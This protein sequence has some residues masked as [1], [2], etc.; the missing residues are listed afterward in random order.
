MIEIILNV[1]PVSWT[2]S[3]IV[4]HHAYNPKGAEK[5]ATQWLIAQEYK[6]A[7]LAGYVKV[8][9]VFFFQIPKSA[10]KKRRALMLSGDIIP[11]SKDNTNMQKFYED[12]L[13]NIV[14]TDDRNVEIISSRK[15]Y[16]EK[17]SVKILVQPRS[18]YHEGNN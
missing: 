16:A 4:H 15:L 9:F 6:D 12:C 3:R 10:S 1:D 8:Q 7:P 13:K 5:R 2:P 11:T 18:E 14:F 17:S